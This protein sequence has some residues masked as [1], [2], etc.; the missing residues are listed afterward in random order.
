[1]AGDAERYRQ[2]VKDCIACLA[3]AKNPKYQVP[4]NQHMKLEKLTELG[5]ELQIDFTGKLHKQKYRPNT[6]KCVNLGL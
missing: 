5:Q 4:K 6:K 2:K 1:M 3:T